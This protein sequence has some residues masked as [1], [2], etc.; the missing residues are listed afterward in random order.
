MFW[1]RW[2]TS[3]TIVAVLKPKVLNDE[4]NI[5]LN[6]RTIII[7]VGI[8]VIVFYRRWVKPDDVRRETKTTGK[9]ASQRC[10]LR[11]NSTLARRIR[12]E[13]QNSD[14]TFRNFERIS[15]RQAAN[16][17]NLLETT[18]C[19]NTIRHFQVIYICSLP[20]EVLALFNGRFVCFELNL[21][22]INLNSIA[23]RINCQFLDNW[24]LIVQ[25]KMN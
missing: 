2:C 23:D 18:S 22:Q 8:I 20:S 10:R 4:L 9:R 25:L 15:S 5:T 6:R 24:L 19:K 3:L 21:T 16:S 7:I 11:N 17:V 14:L 12:F 13:V 1:H